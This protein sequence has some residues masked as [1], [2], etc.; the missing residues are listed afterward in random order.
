MAD[1]DECALRERWQAPWPAPAA[2]SHLEEDVDEGLH[3][4]FHHSQREFAAQLPGNFSRG[5]R[6]HPE[7]SLSISRE[8]RVLSGGPLRS[9]GIQCRRPVTRGAE[10]EEEEEEDEDS[11]RSLLVL[12]ARIDRNGNFVS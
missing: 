10:E 3:L 5:A 7:L 2:A 9:V 4:Q 8:G 1:C 12:G 6:L 11:T